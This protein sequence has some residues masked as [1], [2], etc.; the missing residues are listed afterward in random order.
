MTQ[1][2]TQ[3]PVLPDI[4][5]DG[6]TNGREI[7]AFFVAEL[8]KFIGTYALTFAALLNPLYRWA[9]YA[10][11]RPAFFAISAGLSVCWGAM[12]L[13]VFVFA[14]ALFGGVPKIVGGQGRDDA[15]I[16]CGGEIGA[17]AL[18]YGIV[19]ALILALNGLF[20]AQAYVTLGHQ[21]APLLG[22]A[23]SIAGAV[24]VFA[25]FIGLRKGFVK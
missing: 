10:G 5:N 15:V 3:S 9:L 18:A 12:V 6:I 20:L 4:Q 13:L 19:I 2:D 8:A 21:L 1:F 23:I 11:G 16:T 14:R 22:L 7:A 17:F 25:L 24:I